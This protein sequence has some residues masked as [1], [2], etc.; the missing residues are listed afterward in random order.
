MSK[1][2]YEA[3]KAETGMVLDHWRRVVKYSHTGAS[4]GELVAAARDLF[5]LVGEE[6]IDDPYNSETETEG[7]RELRKSHERMLAALE[8]FADVTV[9]AAPDVSKDERERSVRLDQFGCW[10]R[11]DDGT[12]LAAPQDLDGHFPTVD[13]WGEVSNPETQSFLDAC[14]VVF[15]TDFQLSQFAGR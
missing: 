12:L 15:R 3:E 10:V 1:P 4:L 7:H 8:P 13:E 14:N 6:S 9:S 2:E 5:T 11:V